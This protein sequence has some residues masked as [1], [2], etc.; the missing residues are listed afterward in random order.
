M[1]KK[2]LTAFLFGA[3]LLASTSTFVSCKDYDDD[4]QDVQKQVDAEVTARKALELKVAAAEKAIEDIKAH[5]AE[6]DA[7][8]AAALKDAKEALQAAIDAQEIKENNDYVT[9]NAKID[10]ALVDAK[11]YT[12]AAKALCDAKD[13]ELEGA[14]TNVQNDLSKAITD[15]GALADEVIAARGQYA[16]LKAALDA[17]DAALKAYADQ[18]D[19]TLKA[20]YEKADTEIRGELA[21]AVSTLEKA[22]ADGDDATLKAANDALAAAVSKLEKAVADGDAATLA[23]AKEEIVALSTALKAADQLLED[24]ILACANECKGNFDE[25]NGTI[26]GLKNALKLTASKEDLQN[27]VDDIYVVINEIKD[28]TIPSV[29]TTINNLDVKINVIEAILS[30]KLRSLVFMPELYV[31]GIEAIRYRVLCDT[32]LTKVNID[33]F[34]RQRDWVYKNGTVT[35]D[36]PEPVKKLISNVNDYQYVAPLK[37][38]FFGGTWP[39]EYHMN[40]STSGTVWKDIKK[41]YDRDAKVITRATECTEL[42]ITSPE[43]YEDGV[44]PVF[45]NKNGILTA[46]IKVGKPAT[47]FTNGPKVVTNANPD[48]RYDALSSDGAGFEPNYG[49]YESATGHYSEGK[50]DIVAL[51]VYS[52]VNNKD[53]VIT[54]DYALLYGTKV[55]LDGIVWN[56]K[57]NGLVDK[58][59]VAPYTNHDAS[60]DEKTSNYYGYGTEGETYRCNENIHVWDTPQEALLD[61]KH[62]VQLQYNDEKG[63]VLE[64]YLALH[65]YEENVTRTGWEK[66]QKTNFTDKAL[67]EGHNIWTTYGLTYSFEFV[68]YTI[69]SNVTSD[70]KYAYWKDN[71][72]MNVDL[73]KVDGYVSPT[74]SIIAGTVEKE[75]AETQGKGKRLTMQTKA[76]VDKEPLVRVMVKHGNDVLL[77]GYILVHITEKIITTGKENKV[78]PFENEIKFDLCNDAKALNVNWETFSKTILADT[79]GIE[80][81]VFDNW[82]G[83]EATDVT[84][85]PAINLT[86]GELL[87]GAADGDWANATFVDPTNKLFGIRFDCDLFEAPGKP[88][89]VNTYGRVEYRVNTNGTTNHEYTWYLTAEEMEKIT[90]ESADGKGT[91]SV[92]IRWT[93]K[94]ASPYDYIYSKLTVTI[95]R[96][97][98]AKYS[99]MEKDIN[100]WYSYNT[101]D[102]FA[103]EGDAALSAVLLNVESPKDNGNTK[104]WNPSQLNNWLGNQIFLSKDGHPYVKDVTCHVDLNKKANVVTYSELFD[105]KTSVI[106]FSNGDK[107]LNHVVTGAKFYFA[108]DPQEVVDQTPHFGTAPQTYIIT[109]KSGPND[110]DFEMLIPRYI[111]HRLAY[112][113]PKF[114]TSHDDSP[115]TPAAPTCKLDKEKHKWQLDEAKNNAVLNACAIDYNA[116]VY[117][118]NKLYANQKGTDKYTLI[119]TLDQQSGVLTLMHYEEG[120]DAYKVVCDVLNAVGY[121]L[122][123]ANHHAN[124]IAKELRARI[125]VIAV[126][127]CDL[128]SQMVDATWMASWERPINVNDG[129]RDAID[130][131]SNAN[132]VYVTDFLNMFDWRGPVEGDMNAEKNVWLW[133]YYNVHAITIDCTPAKVKTNLHVNGEDLTTGAETTMDKINPKYCRIWP[134]SLD[135]VNRVKTY[136]FDLHK[137]GYDKNFKTGKSLSPKSFNYKSRSAELYDIMHSDPYTYVNAVKDAHGD[138]LSNADGTPKWEDLKAMFGYIYYDNNMDNVEEFYVKIPVTVHYEWGC[139]T[140]VIKVNI[141][142]TLGN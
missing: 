52:D 69:D 50:D 7:A 127:K 51:Q 57:A 118:N 141:Q 37:E 59:V 38:I 98:V 54:S 133:A 45:S 76:S 14:L 43:F 35:P 80:K 3:T 78:I 106:D 96:E 60:C 65:W 82:F 72:N 36:T 20:A 27:A 130:A 125:G 94:S 117:K 9:L 91:V 67:K 139:F 2:F 25:V 112:S 39:V 55:Y 16:T 44:T 128:A 19:A 79:L 12:D 120:T 28:K 123:S 30:N 86:Y 21:T 88:K 40:P 41:F 33:P 53:T 34:Q 62:L 61:D 90:H 31:D 24:K 105:H 64:D 17:Q 93:G 132:K 77:D 99:L 124:N 42:D 114:F 95:T 81:A 26:V 136:K 116:G 83:A 70:S 140:T 104:T 29:I 58:H 32:A 121:D 108:P 18:G 74:G 100:Y 101:G 8:Q 46:G 71:D 142:T 85:I 131:K 1:N 135:R 11:A 75:T 89:N 87:K 22:I 66:V 102:H 129:E 49:T 97:D 5:E 63:I 56:D 110:V 122:E 109:P 10:Q 111:T 138:V 15:L 73:G 113:S 92:Y 47:L 84:E 107:S 68:N 48:K 137:L 13:A 23:A 115:L 6:C 126:D 134:D 103:V 4:I 119:A